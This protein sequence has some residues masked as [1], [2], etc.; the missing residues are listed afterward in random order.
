MTAPDEV[1]RLSE[2]VK[3]LRQDYD[4]YFLGLERF[5][6]LRAR[7]EVKK[8][9]RRLMT[10][11]IN[12]GTARKFKLQS[13]QASL[14][15]YEAHWNRIARQ[16][17][18]GTFKRD[19]LRAQALMDDEAGT[20]DATAPAAPAARPAAKPTDDAQYP[21]SIRKLHEAFETT[22]KQLGGEAKPISMAALAATVQKQMAAIQ[23]QYQCKTVE[24][25]V[26]VKDGRPI[27]KA[28]PK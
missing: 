19:K 23:A 17:E 20:D 28:I 3:K 6:P 22:R 21:D 24:F 4:K 12:K 8:A 27:L 15:Q 7:D 16:I 2:D 14:T 25:K 13:L 9:L 26:A 1:Q 5:E 10:E 18:E 11:S